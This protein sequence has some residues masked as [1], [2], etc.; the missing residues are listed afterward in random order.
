MT[1]YLD[2]WPVFVAGLGVGATLCYAGLWGYANYR[3][4]FR[5]PNGLTTRGRP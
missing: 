1:L 3:K 5:R 2:S 4:S